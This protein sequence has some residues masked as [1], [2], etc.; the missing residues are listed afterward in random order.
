MS[1]YKA[2]ISYG[3]RVVSAFEVTKGIGEL[4]IATRYS[5]KA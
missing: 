3:R 1:K 2:K 5:K 4:N